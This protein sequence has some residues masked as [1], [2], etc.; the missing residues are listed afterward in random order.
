MSLEFSQ[1]FQD[2]RTR[3][4]EHLVRK[5]GFLDTRM[6]ECSQQ[7]VESGVCKDVEALYTLWDEWKVKFPTPQVVNRL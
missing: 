6:Y 2:D 4:L 5:E 7:A 1:T 3:C